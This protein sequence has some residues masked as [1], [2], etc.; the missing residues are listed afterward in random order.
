MEED[1]HAIDPLVFY[2]RLRACPD[3]F[4]ST[5]LNMSLDA[6]YDALRLYGPDNV[7]SS[8][9]GGK[10]ADVIMHLLRAVCA[11]YGADHKCDC[12]PKLVYFA[13]EDEFDEVIQHIHNN[14]RRYDLNITQY[15]C[16]IVQVCVNHHLA[17]QYFIVYS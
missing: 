15:N 8:Y 12:R 3:A 5:W 16:S 6:L 4:L 11:K 2:T 9:N 10:D 13:N 17:R 14:Q 1:Q 7:F